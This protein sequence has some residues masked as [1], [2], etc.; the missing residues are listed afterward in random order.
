MTEAQDAPGLLGG[1]AHCLVPVPAFP[2]LS[3]QLLATAQAEVYLDKPPVH[4]F[5][6]QALFSIP[7]TTS[8]P[9]LEP[10]RS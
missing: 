9:P 3:P 4:P 8:H 7:Q 6:L 10:S 2:S 1:L 5:I